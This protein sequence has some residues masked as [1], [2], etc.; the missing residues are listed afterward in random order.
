MLSA[1]TNST[2]DIMTLDEVRLRGYGNSSHENDISVI[3]F[4]SSS[5]SFQIRTI[6]CILWNTKG[7]F[8]NNAPFALFHEAR[9]IQKG[10]KN[11]TKAY[12]LNA[13]LMIIS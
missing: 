7:E 2:E 6:F 12:I 11:T 1:S 5:G 13:F 9:M 3:M 8:F 4:Y 10:C